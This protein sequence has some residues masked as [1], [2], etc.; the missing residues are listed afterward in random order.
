MVNLIHIMATI[1]YDQGGSEKM[2]QIKDKL[3]HDIKA[4]DP[5]QCIVFFK[6][7]EPYGELSNMYSGMPIVLIDSDTGQRS[8]WYSS[9]HL[10]QA[11]KYP[12]DLEIC[13]KSRPDC[14]APNV[15]QRIK[16]TKSPLWAK[17]TQKCALPYVR[18][19]W[20]DIKF[21][22]MYWVV[23]LKVQQHPTFVDVLKSTGDKVIV[24]RSSKDREWGAVLDPDGLLRGKN[25]LGQILLMIRDNLDD[26]L[27]QDYST[28]NFFVD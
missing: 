7:S 3:N 28:F 2:W 19:D 11:S 18:S 1:R 24:E 22:V 26:L 5:S 10:Y 16:K 27:K 23:A 13:P 6:L 15:R 17:K 4:Y 21:D 12:K 25:Y 14:N 20:N 8:I 9:E